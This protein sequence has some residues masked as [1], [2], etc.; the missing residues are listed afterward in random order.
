MFSNQPINYQVFAN[1]IFRHLLYIDVIFATNV[2]SGNSLSEGYSTIQKIL[3]E[4]PKSWYLWPNVCSYVIIFSMKSINYACFSEWSFSVSSIFFRHPPP[5]NIPQYWGYCT[6]TNSRH[7]GL[8]VGHHTKK[9]V[10]INN[11]KISTKTIPGHWGAQPRLGACLQVLLHAPR[12]PDQ[13]G[14]TDRLVRA[15]F[16]PEHC[17]RGAR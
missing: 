5:L 11:T 13:S 8:L 2:I 17:A 16:R 15:S 14:A 6:T 1:Y 9:R 4:Q 10:L 7:W 12:E 3:S